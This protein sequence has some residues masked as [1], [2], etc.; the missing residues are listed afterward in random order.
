MTDNMK[1]EGGLAKHPL[2]E[3]MPEE[4]VVEILD[5]SEES[6]VP[7]GT[8]IIRQNDPGDCFYIINTGKVRIYRKGENGIKLELNLLGPGDSFGE[9]ALL[10]GK[11][12]AAFAEAIEETQLTVVSKERFDRVLRKYPD[13][14]F[15]FA[16]KMSNWIVL[17]ELLQ[18]LTS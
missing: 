7:A 8:T 17:S 18:N 16:K 13:L 14:A 4:A 5:V 9:I 6:V 11:A 15:A 2:F 3:D 1:T 10:T 12:R